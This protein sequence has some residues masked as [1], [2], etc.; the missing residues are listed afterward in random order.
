MKNLLLIIIFFIF[1]GCG[2]NNKKNQIFSQS[3]SNVKILDNDNV[4]YMMMSTLVGY[5]DYIIGTYSKN[6]SSLISVVNPYNIIYTKCFLD[7][8]NSDYLV[9]K[10]S[11]YQDYCDDGFNCVQMNIDTD[12]ELLI[13]K[14]FPTYLYQQSTYDNEKYVIGEFDYNQTL[15]FIEYKKPQIVK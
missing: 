4:I 10:C 5:N 12:K 11:T 15:N 2:G 9:Y 14:K 1:I 13:D 8:N 7:T 6:Y 3:F